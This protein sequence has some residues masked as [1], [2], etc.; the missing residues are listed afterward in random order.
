MLWRRFDEFELGTHFDRWAYTVAR[1]CV[2][3]FRKRRARQ[4][5]AFSESAM[6]AI[7]DATANHNERHEEFRDA[8]EHCLGTLSTDDNQLL[9]RRSDLDVTNRQIAHDLGRSESAISRALNRI[10]DALLQCIAAQELTAEE[11]AAP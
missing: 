3:D 6:E 8:L 5:A 1:F 11:G 2:M 9:K 4:D 7:A 10:Y